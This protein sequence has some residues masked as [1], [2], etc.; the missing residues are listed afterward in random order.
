MLKWL[1]LL[2][3]V[4]VLLLSG[5]GLNWRSLNSREF[6]HRYRLTVEIQ[7]DGQTKV[8]SGVIEVVWHK[9]PFSFP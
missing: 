5:V 4:M 7:V 1:A 9:A 3:V 2:T 6:T 8:G